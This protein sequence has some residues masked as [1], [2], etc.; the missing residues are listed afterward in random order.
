MKPKQKRNLWI[1]LG[2]VVLTVLLLVLLLPRSGGS[3]WRVSTEPPSKPR[4]L[5]GEMDPTSPTDATV[6]ADSTIRTDASSAA[7]AAAPSEHPA[8][9][10]LS[11]S[12]EIQYPYDLA[13]GKI[14]ITSLFQYSGMNPDADWEEGENIGV[15]IVVNCSEDYLENLTVTATISDGSTL[16]FQV[17]DLP[18]GQTVWAFAKGNGVFNSR[19][20]CVKLE[21]QS[22][23]TSSADEL[24]T[25]VTAEV[26][27]VEV[28]LS[29]GSDSAV[30]A[31]ELRCHILLNGIYFGGTSYAYPVDEIP[32]GSSTTVTAIDCILGEV[33]VTRLR[34]AE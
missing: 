3:S 23:F 4:G 12:S 18:A 7:N 15:L 6:G 5:T 13:D 22:S 24:G 33:A 8:D 28:N 14:Q 20:A 17:F 30:P 10:N 1:L 32:A 2:A 9:G 19:T 11:T 34:P 16:N 25:A 27:G 29:N 21:S 31:G 26:Q